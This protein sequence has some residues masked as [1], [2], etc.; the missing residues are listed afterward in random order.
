MNWLPSLHAQRNCRPSREARDSAH[1]QHGDAAGRNRSTAANTFVCVMRENRIGALRAQLSGISSTIS[2]GTSV[3]ARIDEQPTASVLVHARG[4]NMRLPA[5]PAEDTGRNDTRM[6]TSEKKI[7]GPTC[8]AAPIRISLLS[9]LETGAA[10]RS[11]RSA[12]C[13]S[14]SPPSRWPR[15]PSTPMANARPPS[16]M[17]VGTHTEQCTS[18]KTKSATAIGSVRNRI[19]RNGVNEI[20]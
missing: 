11:C 3:M 13:D 1:G 10:S 6:M 17:M 7:A 20:Q 16:D 12:R 8:L 2:A 15:Q 9:S 19:R 5:P 14:R 18:A 4:R